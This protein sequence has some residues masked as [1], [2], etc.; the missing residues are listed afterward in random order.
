MASRPQAAKRPA[1]RL[2]LIAP[3]VT[4]PNAV[5]NDIIAAV[6]MADIAAVLLRLAP[7]DERTLV[8]RAKAIAS[9]VQSKNVALILDGHPEIAIR[10]GADG[11]HL[12]GMT[13]FEAAVSRLKPDRIAGVGGLRTRHDSM[14]AGDSGADYVMFG[15][16]DEHGRR[17]S[18][19]A[20]VERVAWWAEL[21]EIPCVAYA[22]RIEEVGELCGAG[23]DFIA[24]GATLFGEPQACAAAIADAMTQPTRTGTPA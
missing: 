4:D 20:I 12:T 10:A 9:A 13:A 7:A 3:V 18:M 11:A 15:E 21:F 6:G 5:T 17:P 22:D 16:P 23:A 14:S 24:I 19:E 8:N 2:Y 1:P